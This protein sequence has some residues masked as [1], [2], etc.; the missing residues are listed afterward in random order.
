MGCH[1]NKGQKLWA[2]R[3]V[4][5]LPSPLL[6]AAGPPRDS[7]G[8]QAPNNV[9]RLAAGKYLH[10]TSLPG[11]PRKAAVARPLE[12]MFCC[13]WVST[14]TMG[15][16]LLALNSDWTATIQSPTTGITTSHCWY[17]SQGVTDWGFRAL[18][19]FGPSQSQDTKHRGFG[20]A[21]IHRTRSQG[22][23]IQPASSRNV[24]VHGVRW[25]P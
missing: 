2:R 7:E 1:L 14:C 5:H 23:R 22:S 6:P 4:H 13:I 17:N 12:C 8:W 21:W 24:M 3:L 19:D 10:S 18:P 20:P 11:F 25:H 15:S 9:Y 16:M